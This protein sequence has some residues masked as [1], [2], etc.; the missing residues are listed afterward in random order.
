MIS[1]DGPR[2]YEFVP[3]IINPV[4]IR[5]ALFLTG[6]ADLR[7]SKRVLEENMPWLRVEILSDPLSAAQTASEEAAV[8]LCDDAGLAVLDG[9]MIRRR[10]PEAVLV[11]LSY[12]PFIQCSPPQVARQRFPYTAKADLVFAVNQSDF[13]PQRIIPSVV[14][15]AEDLLNIRKSSRAR[16]FI[17]HIVDDEPRWF[18]Q[19]LP[20]LYGI[21]GQRA[22]I[23]ITRTYEETLHFIFG[24]DDESRISPHDFQSRGKGDD[25]VCLIADIFLPRGSDLQSA[26]GRDLIHV[27]NRFYPRIPLVIASKAPEAR[28][29]KDLGFILPKGDPDSLERLRDHILNRT[30]LG[31]FLIYDRARQ[32]TAP[33][34]EYS[35]HLP[36]PSRR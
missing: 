11:L 4:K 30:G 7:Q 28:E 20:V 31:D 25:I 12:Q 21:I 32:G 27:I 17:F 13:P 22:D 10:N 34:Q 15:A 5:R 19:F 3:R 16:R 14:R 8:F 24:V 33:G 29:L 26:S 18:S 6:E 1:R 2:E 23:M 9:D 35:R 36:G